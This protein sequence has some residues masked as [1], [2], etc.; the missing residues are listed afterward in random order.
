MAWFGKRLRNMGLDEEI[1]S[2]I[3]KITGEASSL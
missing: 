1:K 2:K 3:E